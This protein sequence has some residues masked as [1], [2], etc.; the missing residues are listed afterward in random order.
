[1]KFCQ[2][3][4]KRQKEAETGQP[5]DA[6]GWRIAENGEMTGQVNAAIGVCVAVT[7]V[8]AVSNPIDALATVSGVG[9]MIWLTLRKD[10][11]CVRLREENHALRE[12]H[13]RMR[14]EAQGLSRELGKRCSDCK[15]AVAANKEFIENHTEHEEVKSE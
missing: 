1:M 7:G 8:Q 4:A 13:A 11:E 12:E 9:L 6:P 15:L 14:T 3:K 5:G 10:R 2:S